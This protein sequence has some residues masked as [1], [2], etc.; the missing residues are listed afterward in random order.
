[1]TTALPLPF[2]CTKNK[3]S[4][5]YTELVISHSQYLSCTR[6]DNEQSTTYQNLKSYKIRHTCI[7]VLPPASATAV[8]AFAFSN[9]D[10]IGSWGCKQAMCNGVNPSLFRA[11]ISSKEFLSCSSCF[12][13]N[14]FLLEQA[15]C[16]SVS[17]PYFSA[18]NGGV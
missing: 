3:H 14:I 11:F 18:L 17:T 9:I 15:L 7:G 5:L 13:C 12:T 16:N 8:S 2:S 4:W 10:T 1:M 6:I